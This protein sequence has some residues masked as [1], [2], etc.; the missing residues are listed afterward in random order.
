ME[1]LLNPGPVSFFLLFVLASIVMIWRL[2]ALEKRGFEGTVIGTLIM[3][4]CSGISNLIFAYIMGRT[5]ESGSIVL[6]NCLVNN[7]TNLTLLLG[8]PA[9]FWSLKVIYKK[10]KVKISMQEQKLNYLSLLFT[11]IAMLFFT[12]AVWALARDRTLDFGDGLVLVGIFLFWQVLHLFEVLK[13]NVR[14]KRR[15]GLAT[16]FDLSLIIACAWGVYYSVEFLVEWVSR[17]D[18]GLFT[19][20][21]IGWLSG[22]IMVF[23]NAILAFYYA[24]LRRAEVVYTSQV[25]DGHICIPMCIG[26]FALFSPIE[27]PASFELGISIIAGAGVLHFLII[28]FLGRL[29]RIAG[30][31][32]TFMYFYFIYKGLLV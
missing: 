1:I 3:P 21:K 23:P 9:I 18:S 15:I 27:I 5:G 10:E 24:K 28:A 31:A 26:L 20:S 30:I 22:L 17:T 16:I 19:F 4:Y 6:E 14:K 32:L 2:G 25:G 13:G 8:A 7:V 11:I 12:G 29:P